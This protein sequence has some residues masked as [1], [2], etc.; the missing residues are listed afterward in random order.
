MHSSDQLSSALGISSGA[1]QVYEHLLKLGKRDHNCPTCSRHMEEADLKIFEKLVSVYHFAAK[2][3]QH[4]MQLKDRMKN[5]SVEKQEELKEELEGWQSELARVQALQPVEASR[6]KLKL[7]EVPQLEAN[8]KEL[9][10]SLPNLIR[11]ADGV[12]AFV[13][14]DARVSRLAFAL[15]SRPAGHS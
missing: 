14:R 11:K 4:Y 13:R 15:G 9:Q 1:L 7:E 5:A 10:D 3:P 6:D 12:R 2:C 8:I